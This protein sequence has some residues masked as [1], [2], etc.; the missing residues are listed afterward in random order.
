MMQSDPKICRYIDIPM[1]HISDKVLK[2]MRREHDSTETR[3]LLSDI[4]TNGA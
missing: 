3:P 2:M 4:R 1:Q